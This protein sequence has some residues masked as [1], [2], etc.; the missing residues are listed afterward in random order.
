MEVPTP[1]QHRVLFSI[2]NPFFSRSSAL[3]RFPYRPILVEKLREKYFC[4]SYITNLRAVVVRAKFIRVKKIYL[5]FENRCGNRSVWSGVSSIFRLQSGD[6]IE[7]ILR[8]LKL[9]HSC[10]YLVYVSESLNSRL[11]LISV[12]NFRGNWS[13]NNLYCRWVR[14]FCKSGEFSTFVMELISEM[15][16]EAE[17]C[18]TIRQV[19]WGYDYS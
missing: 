15:R 14:N 6:R 2:Q 5:S 12:R 18:E 16:L 9:L 7:R 11:F 17:S 19:R 10:L 4:C 8:W 13:E 3:W 1:Y